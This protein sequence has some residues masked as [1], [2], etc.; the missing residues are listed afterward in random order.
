MDRKAFYDAARLAFGPLT[1]TNVAGFNLVLDEAEGRK[2]PLWF[3]A[4]IL[5]TAW[6][7]SGK[8]MAPVEEGYY[9]GSKAEAFQRKLRYYPY[10]GRGLVQLT[11]QDN[12]RKASEVVGVD[13]VANPEKALEPRISVKVLFD[14]MERGWFTGKRLADYIDNIDESDDED[15]REFANARRVVNGTDRQVEIGQLAL[16]FERALRAGGYSGALPPPP[17]ADA[18]PERPESPT[19]A[20][21]PAV[22]AGGIAAALAALALAIWEFLT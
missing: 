13:L 9:L 12:Y 11:W 19:G 20:I 6:W 10:Y 4:K 14:G 2:T 8:T 17:D 7:E 5:A 1:A 3:L 22:K 16:S 15:L 21:P 18:A